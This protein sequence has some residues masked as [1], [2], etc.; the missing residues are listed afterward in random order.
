MGPEPRLLPAAPQGDRRPGTG[1]SLPARRGR[2]QV[3]DHEIVDTF[4]RTA[5]LVAR[6]VEEE[7]YLTWIPVLW[8]DYTS[9]IDGAS[10]SRALFPGPFAPE[11]LG[12]DAAYVR[13]PKKRHGQEPTAAVAAQQ[14]SWCLDRRLR[15][16]RRVPRSLLA[17]RRRGPCRRSG[18]PARGRRRRCAG[19]GGPGGGW[20]ADRAR[21]QGCRACQ[22]R[23]R[24]RV[25]HRLDLP[26]CTVQR[27]GF[28]EGPRGHRGPDGSDRRRRS[29]DD[30]RG[31]VDAGRAGSRRDHGR[32]TDQPPGAG[33]AGAPSQHHGEQHRTALCQRGSLLQP[34]RQDHAPARSGRH[35]AERDGVARLRRQYWTKFGIFGIPPGGEVPDYVVRA[36]TLEQL[37]DACGIDPGGLAKA[38]EEFNPEARAGRDP[39][40]RPGGTLFSASSATTTHGW[41]E[42]RPMLASLRLPRR[43]VPG[44]AR[45]VG[46]V[47][48]PLA[49]RAAKNTTRRRSGPASSGISG[50]NHATQPGES[51]VEH[52]RP[53]RHPA[54]LRGEGGGQ[55]DRNGRRAE[56][57]LARAGARRRRRRHPGP[58]RRGECRR[59]HDPGLLRWGRWDHRPRPG[60][61]FLAGQDAAGR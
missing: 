1:A 10:I 15:H 35:H 11:V 23:V 54:L 14:D 30:V 31:V 34:P 12:E 46:P 43:L 45:A 20:R 36:D 5:P 41:G 18:R 52:A 22:R 9:D 49:A 48:G 4:I 53:R 33:G 39:V 60:L 17:Q 26:R 27:A 44:I 61:R 19:R 6:Y 7:T 37:A 28:P 29:V 2:D 3:L 57:G 8:P 21:E 32:S 58:V 24:R 40:R 55:R 51:A 47:L 42:I 59:R 13:P 56:D 25:R 38:I 50:Q 16:G